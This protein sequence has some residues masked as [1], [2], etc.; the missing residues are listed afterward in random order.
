MKGSIRCLQ[1]VTVCAWCE[2]YLG[3]SRD[4][5]PMVSHGIC[6]PCAARQRW[7]HA[8]VIVVAPHR[9]EMR[10]VLEQLLRGEPAIRVVVDRRAG[11]RRRSRSETD[12]GAERR[13]EPDR[14]RR[15]ADAFL[16]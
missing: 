13:R 3:T 14:R 8:P 1:M 16:I 4:A 12:S 2:R 15:P 6:D 5:G 11:E 10:A 9:A 7:T